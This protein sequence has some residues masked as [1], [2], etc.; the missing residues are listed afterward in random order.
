VLD[1]HRNGLETHF[2][3]AADN[4]LMIVLD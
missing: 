1:F 4:G 2:Y 3:E